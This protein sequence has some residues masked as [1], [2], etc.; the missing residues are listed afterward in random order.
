MN[1]EE[2][3]G[4]K[5]SP[6]E[7]KEGEKKYGDVKYADPK[8]KKY[9]IDT[10]EHVKAALSYF[11]MPRNYNKYTAEERKT[12]LSRIHAAAKKFGVTV[13]RKSA[14]ACDYTTAS[15]TIKFFG[16]K[17]LAKEIEASQEQLSQPTSITGPSDY[18]TPLKA[19]KVLA[20]GQGILNYKTGEYE[21]FPFAKGDTVLFVWGSKVAI[22]E[23][24]F[25]ILSSYDIVGVIQDE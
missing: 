14:K 17:I 18:T 2:A 13:N 3:L 19:G 20:L 1:I 25:Y 6:V 15:L 4:R 5:V 16:D 12:I 23:E 10:A 11:N 24:Q 21:G 8:N 22:G 7:K 9:P